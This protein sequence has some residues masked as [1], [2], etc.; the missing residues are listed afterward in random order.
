[1]NVGETLDI[2]I[3]RLARGGKAVGRMPDGRVIFVAGAAP[4]EVATVE[5]TKVTGKA[6]EGRF[7]KAVKPSTHRRTPPCPV[8][9]QCGGCPWQHVEYAEQVAQ[10]VSILRE[11]LK[12]GHALR[13][14]DLAA[15]REFAASTTEWHYRSRITVHVRRGEIG[16]M[17]RESHDFV[18]I[19]DCLIAH[20]GLVEFARN[21]QPAGSERF[22]VTD[23]PEGPRLGGAFTQVHLEQ[24]AALQRRV[25][26]LMLAH[27]RQQNT[28]AD[29]RLLDLYCGN[30][31]FTYPLVQALHEERPTDVIDAVGVELSAESVRSA[32]SQAAVSGLRFGPRFNLRFEQADVAYW[33]R[34][35]KVESGSKATEVILLDPPRIGCDAEVMAALARRKPSL[36][37]YV[38]CDPSTLARDVSRFHEFCAKSGAEYRVSEFGGFDLFPQTDHIEAVLVLERKG[39]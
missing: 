14:S 17:R 32:R 16:F 20:K 4:G 15:E 18:P 11:T 31:N 12:R 9:L 7:I 8:Y 2:E 26:E 30:G 10:K 1:M 6:L 36:I 35:E 23:S 21:N 37:V 25:T 13:D 34:R 27:L 22:Q 39:N 24:N 38:S 28:P 3:L 5:L 33:I 19:S 29:I